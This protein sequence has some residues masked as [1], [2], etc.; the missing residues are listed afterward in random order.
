M[1]ARA[2]DQFRRRLSINPAG[3]PMNAES[4]AKAEKD[5]LV[6]G[7]FDGKYYRA[8]LTPAGTAA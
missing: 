7:T 5:G 2:L 1:D 4:F 6:Q 8:T 3:V